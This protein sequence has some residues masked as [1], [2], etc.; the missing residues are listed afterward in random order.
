[1]AVAEKYVIF[2]RNGTWPECNVNLHNGGCEEPQPCNYESNWSKIPQGFSCGK[3]LENENH[4]DC[5]DVFAPI[6]C[7]EV[8]VK[9]ANPRNC[10]DGD[11]GDNCYDFPHVF[12]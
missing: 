2:Y 7:S 4:S 6:D 5:N 8:V 1:M 11:F 10:Q 12:N 9:V 3:L